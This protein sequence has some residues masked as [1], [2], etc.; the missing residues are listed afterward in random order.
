MTLPLQVP[1]ALAAARPTAAGRLVTSLAAYR[2]LT[3]RARRAFWAVAYT[4]RDPRAY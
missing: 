1:G 2:L 3:Y 4:A